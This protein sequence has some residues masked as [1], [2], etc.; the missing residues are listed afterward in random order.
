[1]LLAAPIV[2]GAG[3]GYIHSNMSSPS[4]L[5][6][7]TAQQAMELAELQEMETEMNRQKDVDKYKSKRGVT[8]ERTLRI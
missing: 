1:M 8:G 3:A 6:S 2:G 5:D 4:K 7:R